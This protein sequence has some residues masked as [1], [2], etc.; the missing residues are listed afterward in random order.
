MSLISR[1]FR[2]REA[3]ILVMLVLFALAVGLI[4]PRFL[5]V[6]TL[7]IVLLAVPLIMVRNF[8]AAVRFSGLSFSY[9]LAYAIF[10]G[11]TPPLVALLTSGNRLGAAHYVAVMCVIGVGMGLFGVRRHMSNDVS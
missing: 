6:E 3:G 5:T 9:N 1:L 10:G 11:F 4:Q 2:A 7:R 8:P